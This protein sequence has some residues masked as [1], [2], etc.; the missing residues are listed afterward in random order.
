MSAI[1]DYSYYS[2][3]YKGED[4]DQASFPALCAR[5]EDIVGAMTRWQVTEDNFATYPVML[6]ALYKKAI[7]AQV[8]FLGVNGLDSLA[9]SAGSETG[10]TVGKVTI[11]GRS[12]S[13]ACG[14]MTENIAPMARL[15]LEQTW[16]MGPAVPTVDSAPGFWGWW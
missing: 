16:L 2:D 3:V 8:E 4:V 10:F 11:H 12:N 6:Q 15:Y 5:A 13:G 7:C 9:M 1:V 14:A